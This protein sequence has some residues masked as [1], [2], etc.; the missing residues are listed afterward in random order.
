VAFDEHLADRVR[1]V[2]GDRNGLSERK[3]FGGI[4]FMID[5]N[6]ACGVINGDLIVRLDPEDAEKALSEEDV[7]VFDYSGRPMK[8]WIYV[9]P[10]ATTSEE[11]L[12]SWVEA[13]ADHAASLPPKG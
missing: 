7:R 1:D 4:G 5:G 2:L 9:G 8:G 10:D 13:G 6:M 12:A 11:G 3:M